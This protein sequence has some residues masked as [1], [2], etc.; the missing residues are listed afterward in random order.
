L[1]SDKG[2]L[3]PF[4]ASF[5]GFDEPGFKIPYQVTIMS[6]EKHTV[7]SNTLVKNAH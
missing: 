7:L 5:S 2:A 6:P 4:F 3:A 1:S